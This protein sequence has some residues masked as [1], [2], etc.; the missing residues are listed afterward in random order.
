M[1]FGS[2]SH[3][4]IDCGFDKMENSAQDAERDTKGVSGAAVF[5]AGAT[6]IAGS[7]LLQYLYDITAERAVN[8]KRTPKFSKFGSELRSFLSNQPNQEAM[9]LVEGSVEQYDNKALTSLNGQLDGAGKVVV[10]T[11]H[12]KS[13]VENTEN[14][15][16]NT[17]R[18]TENVRISVPFALRDS[19]NNVIVVEAVD[20]ANGFDQLLH[21]AYQ[22]HLTDRG[23]TMGDYATGMTLQEIPVSISTQEYLLVFGTKFGGYGRAV[24]TSAGTS[25]LRGQSKIVKFYPEEVGTSIKHLID[26]QEFLARAFRWLSWVFFVGGGFVIVFFAA[27][28]VWRILQGR[29]P[30]RYSR[31][32]SITD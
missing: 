16:R 9:V 10:T 13:K 18:T 19:N 22:E 7:Y 25:W 29:R 14:T 4:R 15:W 11:E 26:E 30:T 12:F 21:L 31:P 8:F 5:V 24:L 32:R 28:Y 2:I 20:N 3:R 23:R 6:A 27:P 1:T 17:S